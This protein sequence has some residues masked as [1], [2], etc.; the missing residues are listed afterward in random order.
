[1]LSGARTTL[2]LSETS[3]IDGLALSRVLAIRSK[4]LWRTQR[5]VLFLVYG[6]GRDKLIQFRIKG[7]YIFMCC[8]TLLRTDKLTVKFCFKQ[9]HLVREY[10]QFCVLCLNVRLLMWNQ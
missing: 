10:L 3:A 8:S 1:M 6:C 5:T 9:N 7:F 4:Q 2:L